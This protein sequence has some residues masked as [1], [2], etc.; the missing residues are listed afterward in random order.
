MCAH[1]LYARVHVCILCA[2]VHKHYLFVR[3]HYVHVR[4]C[5]ICV[6]VNTFNAR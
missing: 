1:L 4:A 2:C 6:C 5:I 3:I